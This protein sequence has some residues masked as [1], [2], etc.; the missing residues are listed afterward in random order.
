MKP[1]CPVIASDALLPDADPAGI[2][3]EMAGAERRDPVLLVG[4]EP[5]LGLLGARLLGST[6]PRVVLRKGGLARIDAD[7]PAPGAGRLIWMLTPR[8]LRM[9]GEAR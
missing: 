1:G 5:H 2:L 8:Q 7:E 3:A 4:H 6:G 9:I